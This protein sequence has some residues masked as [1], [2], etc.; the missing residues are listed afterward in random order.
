MFPEGK[1]DPSTRKQANFAKNTAQWHE[2][3][4]P[5]VVEHYADGT[6]W[7]GTDL[8]VPQLEQQDQWVV[9]Q[10]NDTGVQVASNDYYNSLG[11]EYGVGD[12]VSDVPTKTVPRKEQL[13][14]VTEFYDDTPTVGKPAIIPTQPTAVV[15]VPKQPTTDASNK[16]A[17][18]VT[19]KPVV[20]AVVPTALLTNTT[21]LT[22]QQI[23]AAV[24]DQSVPEMPDQTQAETERL[25]R[26]NDV[27][28]VA[29]GDMVAAS[30]A[31]RSREESIRNYLKMQGYDD[32]KPKD[33][34]GFIES[35]KNAFTFSGAK[36]ALGLNNQEIARLAVMTLGGRARG[37]N[38]GQSLAFAGR[39]AFMESSRRQAQEDADRKAAMR[40][41]VT[42]AQ[43]DER[44]AQVDARALAK[45]KHDRFLADQQVRMAEIKAEYERTKDERRY[46]QQL[47]I[48]ANRERRMYGMLAQQ[49]QQQLALVYARENAQHNSPQA[50]LDRR[51]KNVDTSAAAV[52]SI[53]DRDLGS[54]DIKGQ[55]NPGRQ[56]LP[57]PKQ[58]GQ[59][60]LSFFKNAGV[61]VDNTDVYQE[62]NAAINQA[63]EEMIR[64]RKMNK[65]GNINSI[66]PYLA[67]NIITHRMGT[68]KEMFM[69]GDKEMPPNKIAEVYGNISK[70][71]SNANG[72]VPNDRKVAEIV[73]LMQQQWNSPE[74]KKL[75]S[76]FKGNENETAFYQYLKSKF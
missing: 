50:V 37:F 28:P 1:Y 26:Q 54:A 40:N 30:N 11:N 75:R 6:E 57:T 67:R 62:S 53:Y 41:A 42:M 48:E 16:P 55:P 31:L 36:E 2:D 4:T 7:A 38:L 25:Q 49:G 39:N 18:P 3:G 33:E 61:D 72:G 23:E 24:V 58:V 10:V 73:G 20:K 21:G 8:Q 15:E 60:A 70:Q 19:A 59:Q 71:V 46:A 65:G 5:Q 9:P 64:D 22:P 29:P 52:S 44:N 47:E 74:G 45:E 69:V 35:F 17:V 32:S 66:A 34:K 76:Q 14:T 51:A 12:V 68:S 27:I 56:G 13:P 63:T 43:Q